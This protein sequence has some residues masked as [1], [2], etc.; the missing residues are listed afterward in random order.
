MA[1]S[2]RRAAVPVEDRE[3]LSDEALTRLAK[4][5]VTVSSAADEINDEYKRTWEAV[6]A[7]LVRRKQRRF[8]FQMADGP[9]VV[10]YDTAKAADVL[11]FLQLESVLDAELWEAI[12]VEGPRLVDSDLLAAAVADG[13]IKASVVQECVVTGNE[14]VRRFGP[15]KVKETKA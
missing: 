15:K 12:T 8:E 10:G 11:D 2:L 6:R 14:V 5:L 13:R 1:S 7:E 9:R 4:S 3:G